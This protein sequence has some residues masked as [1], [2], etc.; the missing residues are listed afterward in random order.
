MHRAVACFSC[1][2][3]RLSVIIISRRKMLIYILTAKKNATSWS[4]PSLDGRMVKCVFVRLCEFYEFIIGPYF[5]IKSY[6][7]LKS[8]HPDPDR[9]RS[10]QTIIIRRGWKLRATTSMKSQQQQ[11][12]IINILNKKNCI[13]LNQHIKKFR[14]LRVIKN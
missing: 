14:L 6:Y 9:A 12:Q 10:D 11:I 8:T 4:S 7:K 13:F 2:F 1:G 3:N 5:H